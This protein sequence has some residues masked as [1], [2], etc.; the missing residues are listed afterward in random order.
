[1]AAHTA[2]RRAHLWDCYRF[3]WP[4]LGAALLAGRRLPVPEPRLPGDNAYW[5]KDPTPATGNSS[6]LH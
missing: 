2:L 4:A 5:V 6:G 3:K 1:M